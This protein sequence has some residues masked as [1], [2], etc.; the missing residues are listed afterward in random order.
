MT[1]ICT[2]LTGDCI[3]HAT[4][5]YLTQVQ[6]DGTLKVV[7]SQK[8]KMVAV[9]HFRGA[10][11]FC[12]FAG[13]ANQTMLDWL[14]TRAQQAR[15]HATPDLFAS[16]L[17]QELDTWLQS[18]AGPLK[19]KGVGLHFTAYEA[20]KSGDVPEL[21][22]ITNWNGAYTVLPHPVAQRQTFITVT[23]GRQL[24]AADQPKQTERQAVKLALQVPYNFL[25]YNQGDHQLFNSQAKAILDSAHVLRQR[26]LLI[27]DKIEYAGR[28]ALMPVE[29]VCSMQQRLSRRGTRKV[30]GKPHNLIITPQG[31]YKS[32]TGVRLIPGT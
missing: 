22:W 20:L 21:F 3:V 13:F 12:G 26:G 6:R 10:I 25:Q 24:P 1:V 14:S 5:S 17:T 15:Q 31:E 8:P 11:S 16:W 2:L 23:N 28:L 18:V 4:D 7:E 29:A 30:G 19:N 32:H 27:P 9:R